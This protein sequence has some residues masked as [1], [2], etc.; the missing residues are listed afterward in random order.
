[1]K[2]VK[3]L[4]PTRAFDGTPSVKREPRIGDV[5]TIVYGNQGLN[6]WSAEMVDADGMT[7]WLADFSSEEL[8]KVR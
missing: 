3:L 2:I 6:L 5:G 1:M 8:Q 7:V 4:N